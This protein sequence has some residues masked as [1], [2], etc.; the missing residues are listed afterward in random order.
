MATRTFFRD[1]QEWDWIPAGSTPPGRWPS[2]RSVN[3]LIGTNPRVIA[4]EAWAKLQ[5]A[6][7]NLEP[8]NLPRCA[9][10][11]YPM[12][13]IRTV[14]LT[15]LFSGLRS[16]D[17]SRLRVGCVRWQHDGQPIPGDSADVL[18]DDAVC[19]LDVPVHKTGTAFTKP[20][21]PIVSAGLA[22]HVRLAS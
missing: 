20:V 22:R 1:C 19:L 10:S 4:D 14:T 18:A 9:D 16:D 15:W 5:W 17:I 13:L 3:A 7:L 2:P 6:G 12:E 21:D 8:A 11:F